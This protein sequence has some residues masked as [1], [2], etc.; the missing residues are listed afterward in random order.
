M[1]TYTSLADTYGFIAIY[2]SSTHDGNCWDVASNKSLTH[3][4]GGDSNGL[5]NMLRYTISTYNA[6][7]SKIFVT[8]SSS[9]GMMTNVMC[10][11]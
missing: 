9:G 5:A 11:V 2:P 6:D 1:T 4:G 7:T 8:G 10:A 3:E